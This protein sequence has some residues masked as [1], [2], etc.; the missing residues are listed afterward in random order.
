MPAPCAKYCTRDPRKSLTSA[1][2][3]LHQILVRFKAFLISSLVTGKNMGAFAG[4]ILFNYVGTSCL[5]FS[6]V[7]P[8]LISFLYGASEPLE[9]HVHP[10]DMLRNIP[11]KHITQRVLRGRARGARARRCVW[12]G[13]VR[14]VGLRYA[15]QHV[16]VCGAIHLVWGVFA[17]GAGVFLHLFLRLCKYCIVGV[18]KKYVFGGRRVWEEGA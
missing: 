7:F 1:R 6:A 15:V 2:Y 4:Y 13:V 18:C 12:V 5:I 8:A 17:R 16:L 9:I 10:P 3:I 11:L 14:V